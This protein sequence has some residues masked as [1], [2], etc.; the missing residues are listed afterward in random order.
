MVYDLINLHKIRRI[1]LYALCLLLALLLQ[2]TVLSRVSLLGVKAMILP[3]LLTAVGLFEGGWWGGL[4]GLAAGVVCDVTSSDTRLLY[5]LLYALIGFLA[6]YLGE[7]LI[8]RRFVSYM[9]LAA[10]SLL[11]SA[12]V[13][14]LPMWI[15]WGAPLPALLRTGAL[16]AAWSLPFAV[17]AYFA[18]K[19]IARREPV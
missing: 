13:R 16:E 12:A 15:Y 5:T 14:V 10:L 6:G 1:L 18:C 17:P 9:V 4:F 3:V 11:L 19:A 7:E 2:Q 8:N